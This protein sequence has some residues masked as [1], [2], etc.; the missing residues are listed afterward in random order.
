MLW[1]FPDRDSPP[2]SLGFPNSE[3][4]G[5]SV[6]RVTGYTLALAVSGLILGEPHP[7]RCTGPPPQLTFHNATQHERALG[8]KK[9]RPAW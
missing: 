4:L 3:F 6:A 9:L 5:K 7:R 2:T 1:M 8:W